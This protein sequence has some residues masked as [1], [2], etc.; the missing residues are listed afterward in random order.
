MIE[1]IRTITEN[2]AKAM[3]CTAD[4]DI[5]HLYP[6]VINHSTETKHIV[7]LATKWFGPEHVTDEDLPL[8]AGEDFSYFI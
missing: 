6:A 1:R 5:T 8:S 3:N 4:I 7:R 2:I